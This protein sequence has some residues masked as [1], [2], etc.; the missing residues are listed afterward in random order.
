MKLN[1]CT[2]QHNHQFQKNCFL[3]VEN[4]LTPKSTLAFVMSCGIG[5]PLS[6][7]LDILLE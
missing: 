7:S 1:A 5:I 4:S 3:H 6:L 2:I